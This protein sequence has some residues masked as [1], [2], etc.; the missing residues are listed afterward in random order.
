MTHRLNLLRVCCKEKLLCFQRCV[1]M[2]VCS[3]ACMRVGGRQWDLTAMNGS[4]K[5]YCCQ[6]VLQVIEL[7]KSD[8]HADVGCAR[9]LTVSC[10]FCPAT[11]GCQPGSGS[12]QPYT[13]VASESAC[14]VRVYRSALHNGIVIKLGSCKTSSAQPRSGQW[15][16]VT[17]TQLLLP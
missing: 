6:V 10:R 17:V 15:R 16:K 2:G 1:L 4:C 8:D 9:Q 14:L 12:C 7:G 5:Q 13:S 3:N 11:T